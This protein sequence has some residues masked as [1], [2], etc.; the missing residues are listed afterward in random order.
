LEIEELREHEN[1]DI[2]HYLFVDAH[3]TWWNQGKSYLCRIIDML[4][5]GYL[6][7][8][9]FGYEVVERLPHI[10]AEWVKIYQ[11]GSNK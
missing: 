2:K 9:L 5:M 8:V 1:M 6:D 4:P 3:D 11:S 10:V 7:E